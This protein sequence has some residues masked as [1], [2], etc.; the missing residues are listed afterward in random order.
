ME[1]ES[2]L[3]AARLRAQTYSAELAKAFEMSRVQERQEATLGGAREEE[4][5][6]ERKT[7]QSLLASELAEKENQLSIAYSSAQA[8]SVELAATQK[9]LREEISYAQARQSAQKASRAVDAR[10][11]DKELSE[12][13]QKSQQLSKEL[14]DEE[15][16]LPGA[17][18]RAQTFSVELATAWD[19]LQVEQVLS[20]E[21]DKCR[22]ELQDTSSHP[23]SQKRK[24]SRSPLS[25][26]DRVG[27]KE[28]NHEE[29]LTAAQATAQRLSAE[30]ASTWYE[31]QDMTHELDRQALLLVEKDREL[32]NL[33]SKLEQNFV[34]QMFQ[35]QKDL[36]GSPRSPATRAL[37]R[38]WGSLSS[39]IQQ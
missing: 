25:T 29:E 6:Q 34:Q 13:H 15:D 9:K 12:A 7:T 36:P 38:R 26:V 4:F 3:S 11:R 35:E 20:A 5:S 24:L 1:N 37:Y 16:Q 8:F 22:G 19:R 27:A 33:R 14:A 39:P 31:L 21:S 2:Q 30:L 23:T 10:A 17:C 32:E 18:M 28:K